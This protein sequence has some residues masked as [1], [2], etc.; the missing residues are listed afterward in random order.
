MTSVVMCFGGERLAAVTCRFEAELFY[1]SDCIRQNKDPEPSGYEGLADVRIIE[2][3]YKSART[4]RMVVLPEISKDRRPT[5]RQEINRPAHV[6][7]K[8][9]NAKSPSGKA[10]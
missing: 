9:V 4:G 5:K 6:L 1:F 7:P 10:A 3:I 8:T 2:A